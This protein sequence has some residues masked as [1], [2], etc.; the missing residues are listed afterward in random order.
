[1]TSDHIWYLVATGNPWEPHGMALKHTDS[2]KINVEIQILYQE[3]QWKPHNSI[4]FNVI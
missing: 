4:I 2:I 3:C 1:M